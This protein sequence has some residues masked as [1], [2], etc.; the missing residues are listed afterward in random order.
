[1]DDAEQQVLGSDVVVLE[2]GCLLAGEVDH[3][4]NAF[5]ELVVH[6]SPWTPWVGPFHAAARDGRPGADAGH[7]VRR[8]S[9]WIRFMSSAQPR[10][11]RRSAARARAGPGRRCAR[12]ASA[13]HRAC[14]AGERAGSGRAVH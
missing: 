2:A 12:P 7:T 11:L 1:A 3:L 10:A 4:A 13:P 6:G 14:A 5:G 8:R 9:S